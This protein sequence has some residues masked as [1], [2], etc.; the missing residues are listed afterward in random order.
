M[1]LNLKH[2]DFP[3]HTRKQPV[4]DTYHNKEIVDPYR[5][6]EDRDNP[7]VKDWIEKQNQYSRTFLDKM[8]E[9]SNI[10]NKLSSLHSIG[11]H[12]VPIV[13]N[14]TYFYRK[15][16]GLQNQDV[17]MI[18]LHL[19][20]VENILFDPN[21][22]DTKGLMAID[23]FF[24]SEDGT[25]VAVG[26]STNGSELSVLHIINTTTGELLPYSIPQTRRCE[27]AWLQDSTGFYYTRYPA[28]G[29][30]PS[31]GENYNQRIFF[32][33]L[34]SDYHNDTEIFGKGEDPKNVYVVELSCDNTS[35]LITSHQFNRTKLFIGR[36]RNGQSPVEIIPVFEE[37]KYSSFGFLWK[38]FLYIL[39]NYQ[40]KNWTVYRT[41]LATPELDHWK[42]LI[43]EGKSVIEDIEIAGDYLILH[44]LQ[45]VFSYLKV[46][47]LEGKFLY[48]IPLPYKGSVNSVHTILNSERAKPI[49]YFNF[50]SFFHPL[51]VIILI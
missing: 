35:L 50:Q 8:P 34:R 24:P 30:V 3:P 26:I 29:T 33:Q 32:H 49:I 9:R 12:H 42:I 19:N 28:L 27:I 51:P 31:G 2:G 38:N 47:S 41:P 25:H 1:T 23:W 43:P 16:T 11:W 46:Y 5:W 14:G 48:T 17:L 4:S 40:A 37:P 20:G 10:K 22:R 21:Q 6:L 7:E 44:I 39:T 18:R 15:R 45:N 13:K 36:L